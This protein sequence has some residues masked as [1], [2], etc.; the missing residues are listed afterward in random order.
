MTLEQF[1]TELRKTKG[2]RLMGG[3]GIRNG[4]H[5]PITKI[6]ARKDSSIGDADYYAEAGRLLGLRRD[7]ADRIVA[8]ADGYSDANP[9]LRARLL[10]AC[11]LDEGGKA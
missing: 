4:C 9:R 7:V 11:G 10:A 5:C 2:W 6:A 8:A 3:R 1:L